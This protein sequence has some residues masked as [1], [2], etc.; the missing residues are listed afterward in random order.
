ME[1]EKK[2]FLVL[3]AL[4]TLLS[5]LQSGFKEEVLNKEKLNLFIYLFIVSEA[6][7]I[8]ALRITFFIVL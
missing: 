2:Q 1:L 6:K 4:K 8:P 7:Y 3:V 5:R